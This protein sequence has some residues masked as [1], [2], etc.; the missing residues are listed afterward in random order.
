MSMPYFLFHRILMVTGGDM[1]GNQ[2]TE[3]DEGLEGYRNPTQ[4]GAYEPG[5]TVRLSVEMPAF[6]TLP[7]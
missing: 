2:E 5:V 6:S 7:H 4:Q 3:G 1:K